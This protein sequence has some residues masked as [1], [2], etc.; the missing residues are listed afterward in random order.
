VAG[1][2]LLHAA[3]CAA[4]VQSLG[5]YQE[6]A[7]WYDAAY[8]DT[9]LTLAT[10]G[11]AYAGDNRAALF[12]VALSR[13]RRGP[14]HF[15]LTWSYVFRRGTPSPQWGVGDPKVF[16]RVPLLRRPATTVFLEAAARLPVAEA[17]LFPYACG[18]QEVEILAVLAVPAWGLHVGA[19]RQFTEPPNDSGLGTAD[20]PHATH[21]WLQLT[22]GGAGFTGQVRADA[23]VFE[24]EGHARWL[25]EARLLHGDPQRFVTRLVAK[26]EAGPDRLYDYGIEIGFATRLR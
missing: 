17:D 22:V 5:L 18:G 10:G 16:A 2:A 12:H 9:T 1:G 6:P 19:G 4:P 23:L 15:A 8:S 7:P 25:G 21:A 14:V 20:M 3:L 24:L 13:L 11:S 26:A